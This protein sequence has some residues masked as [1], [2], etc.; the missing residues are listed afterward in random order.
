MLNDQ[1]FL[2]LIKKIRRIVF[3]NLFD[4]CI[5]LGILALIIACLANAFQWLLWG[6]D[7]NVITQNLPLYLFGIFP[8]EQRWRP[9]LWLFFLGSLVVITL[10][11]PRWNWLRTLL[12]IAWIGL[13]PL[14]VGLLS[15]G[16]GL[17]PV[18]SRYWGGLTLTIFLMSCSTLLAFPI[19]IILAIGRQSE[20][21]LIKHVSGIYIDSLRAVPLIAI[22]FFG[23][24]LIP[25]FLPLGLEINR[26]N[27]SLIHI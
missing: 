22:L 9:A 11:K 15:G 23:Q 26:V 10:F 14:G 16:L 20:L 24:L 8:S 5:T 13:V 1:L 3:S 4:T 18:A 12:P 21:P 6:A 27:L 2:K 19:G 17:L 25:L 7:W